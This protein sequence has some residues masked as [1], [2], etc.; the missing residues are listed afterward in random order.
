[1]HYIEITCLLLGLYLMP[2]ITTGLNHNERWTRIQHNN[3]WVEP[4]IESTQLGNELCVIG[5]IKIP[6]VKCCPIIFL[7]HQTTG[8]PLETGCLDVPLRHL[9][10]FIPYVYS[11]LYQLD[12]RRT[13]PDDEIICNRDNEGNY[14]CDFGLGIDRTM[15]TSGIGKLYIFYPCEERKSIDVFIDLEFQIENKTLL[16]KSQGFSNC[17]PLDPDSWCTKYYN[18]TYIAWPNLFGLL[19][20]MDNIDQKLK[21]LLNLFMA[22]NCHKHAEELLCLAFFPR[23]IGEKRLLPCRSSC[24]EV[25]A[26]CIHKIDFHGDLHAFFFKQLPIYESWIV[27]AELASKVWCSELPETDIDD[28]YKTEPITCE[29]PALVEHGTHNSDQST[30]HFNSSKALYPVQTTLEY[31]CNSGYKLDGNGTISCEYFGNW[32]HVPKCIIETDDNELIILSSIFGTLIILVVVVG[33][34]CWKYRREI[35]ALL[36]AKFGIKFIR[37]KEENRRYDA[38]IAYSQEDFNFVKQNLIDPLEKR[39][40]KICIPERDFEPRDYKSQNVI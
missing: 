28:C 25:F 32:S 21:L 6:I 8:L 36:Y 2:V 12:W 11:V 39:N 27:Y 4:L 30:H 37:E 1:M 24:I 26:T 13:Y 14:I 9:K 34:I 3:S 20:N 19:D 33:F 29:Q 17:L 15:P 18:S 35:S 22:A 23:C 40:F 5:Q 7:T 16:M 38:L 31:E 10:N